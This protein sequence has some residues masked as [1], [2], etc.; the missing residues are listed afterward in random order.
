V[1]KVLVA[2]ASGYLGRF[3]AREFKE[4]GFWVRVLARNPDRLKTPGPFLEPATYDFADEVFVGEVTK[5]E[6]LQGI[7]ENVE[8]VFSSIGITRQRDRLSYMDVDYEGN[9]NLLGLALKASVRKF[10][11]VHGFNALMLNSLDNMQAKQR[12][13]EALRQSGLPYAIVCPNGFFND[14]SE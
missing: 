9:K 10:I 4:R 5:P 13:V 3:V 8:V 2:G 11:F 14:M 1:S 7:C 12:F 6:T